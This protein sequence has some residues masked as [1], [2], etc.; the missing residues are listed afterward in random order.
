[1]TNS[2]NCVIISI[3]IAGKPAVKFWREQMRTCYV[4]VMFTIM[5]TVG[6]TLMAVR[7]EDNLE[8][9]AT[10]QHQFVVAENQS[11]LFSKAKVF[12]SGK[13]SVECIQNGIKLGSAKLNVPDGKQLLLRCRNISMFGTWFPRATWSGV[14]R[15]DR[16]VRLDSYT[17]GYGVMNVWATPNQ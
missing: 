10:S 12:D 7:L 15:K 14:L 5:L 9:A 16:T 1:M 4:V 3:E 11:R 13:Y 2:N 8:Y 17:S 6:V